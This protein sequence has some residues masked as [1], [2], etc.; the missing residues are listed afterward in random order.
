MFVDIV[1]ST[2][3]AAAVGDWAWR[4][5]VGRF[6]TLVR[7]RLGRSG[8]REIDTAGDG[9]LACFDSPAAAI[10]CAAALGRDL[11]PLEISVRVGLH[12]GECELIGDKVGGLAVHIGARVAAEAE[13]GEVLVS[14]TVR[15]LVAGSAIGFMERGPRSLRGVPGEWRLFAVDR[16]TVARDSGRRNGVDLVGR[17]AECAR[18]DGLLADARAG[19]S[20]AIVLR[21]EAGIGKSALLRYA[22][23]QADG[24]TVLRATGVE[25]ECE[26]PFA[27]LADFFRPAIDR[28]SA[29][30]EAQAAALAAALALAPPVGA[31][32]FAVCAATV[33]LLAALAESG[34]VLGAVDEAHWLD[35]SSLEALLFAARRL[36]AEGI[37][38]LFAAR[39]GD[40]DA[41]S[42]AG[43]EE[44]TLAGLSKEEGSALLA[45]HLEREPAP[46][47]SARLVAATRGNPL[48]LLEV[49]TLL[50]DAQLAGEEPIEGHLPVTPLIERALLGRVAVLPEEVRW[51]LVVAATSESGRLE[52]VVAAT[53]S[54]SVDAEALDRAEEAGLITV[55]Q[56]RIEFRHPLLRSAIYQ[57]T[58]GGRRQAVHE[59]LAAASLAAGLRPAAAWH[60]AVAAPAP[61]AEVAAALEQAA[62]EA[63]ARG[64][65]AEAASAFERAARLTA[66]EDLRARRLREAAD[67][68]RIGGRAERALELLEQALDCATEPLLQARIHHLRGAV[69]M[70]HGAPK[71]A[72]ELL[73]HQAE[74]VAEFDPAR[75]ARMLTDAAWA[76]FLAADITRGR[77]TAERACA[78]VE[79]TGGVAEILA[80]AVLGLAFLLSGEVERAAPL[81]G[82]YRESFGAEAGFVRAYQLLRPSGHVLTWV[83]QYD[84][85]EEVLARMIDAA[86]SRGALGTLPFLLA[87]LSDVEFRTGRWASG[88]AHAAEA[89][90]IA[91]DTDDETMLAYA[92]ACLARLEAAQGHV[93]CRAHVDRAI[94]LG[95]RRIGA[96]VAY[97]LSALGL[98]ELGTGRNDD[99]VAVLE[100]LAEQVEARGLREPS[101]VQWAP[102]LVEACA[103]SGRREQAERVLR[104]FEEDAAKSERIWARAA[105]ARC[106]GLLAGDRELD[107]LFEEAFSW[108]AQTATPFELARTQLCFGER[109]RRVRRRADARAPLRRALDTFERLGA[110][111]WEERTRAELEATGETVQRRDPYG[112]EQLTPQELQVAAVVA[113]GATNKEAGAALFLSPKTIEA[114]LGRI[115][116]KLGLRSR[117]DLARLLTSQGVI[118]EESAAPR[119][120]H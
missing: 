19:R 56:G 1:G 15:D 116:R 83:E 46:D 28:L 108:H 25:S 8:G 75:A 74:G 68:A 58:P 80:G 44:L 54:L 114:H 7:A 32:R 81:L 50:T 72:R 84:G 9:F 86:R 85:A 104:R 66:G 40:V 93:D 117:T 34:P 107:E 64:G 49:P 11:R 110:K 24:M 118:A 35:A 99:A 120:L 4:E 57:T 88:S 71:E 21:G 20:G 60:R 76:S 27:A 62:R 94:A 47:A 90:R 45:R 95:S 38:L 13:A 3:R 6:Q 89:V 52:E 59:A 23:E 37:A 112:A 65:H 82:R 119:S 26:L 79:G 78:L 92:L 97:A 100:V 63:R 67:D 103:R 111:P 87:G 106:R 91:E 96:V 14:Q 43:I 113:R 70:W 17:T 36:D 105:A 73:A 55:E 16:A 53:R 41:L 29:L 5:L 2:E 30:P 22:L 31:D 69:L 12:T 10:R 102:D 42:R 61:D 115:Y 109:L 48:A 33:G 18:V 51:A 101:V 98:V 39:E 77:S